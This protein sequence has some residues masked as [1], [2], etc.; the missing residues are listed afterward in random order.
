MREYASKA[1]VR[2]ITIMRLLGFIVTL[3]LIRE[4]NQ[5]QAMSVTCT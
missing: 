4:V 3:L 1:G 5:V 2:N